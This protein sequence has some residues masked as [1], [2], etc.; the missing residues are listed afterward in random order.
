MS[1]AALAL[2]AV[3]LLSILMVFGTHGIV[4]GVVERMIL[5]RVFRKLNDRHMPHV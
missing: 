1:Y 5:K 4:M 3:E 2:V